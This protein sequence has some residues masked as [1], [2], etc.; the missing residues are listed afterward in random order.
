MLIDSQIPVPIIGWLTITAILDV[1]IS[2]I[3]IYALMRV[4]T[5][6]RK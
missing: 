5:P 3:L 2:A 4:K 6:F 1:G